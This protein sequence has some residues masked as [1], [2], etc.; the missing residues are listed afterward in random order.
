MSLPIRAL[1]LKNFNLVHLFL[2]DIVVIF[3]FFPVYKFDFLY[4]WDDQWFV[5]NHYTT[6]GF[7]RENCWAIMTEFYRGQYAPLNQFYYTTLYQFLEFEPVVYHLSNVA[8]HMVNIV[9][10]YYLIRRVCRHLGQTADLKISQIAFVTS[11]FFAILPINLEPVVWVAA[12]KVLLYAIFYFSALRCY[13]KYLEENKQKYYY[14]TLLFFCISF[15]AKEQAVS[16]PVC[17]LLIDYLFKRKFN[18]KNLWL[19]KL[20]MLVLSLLFG[21]I[22][23]QS[24]TNAGSNFYEIHQ[25]FALAFYTYVEYFAKSL[26][27]VNLSYLYPF[28]FLVGQPMPWW[29]WIYPIA[30]PVIIYC[31]CLKMNKYIVFGLLFFTVHIILVLNLLSLARFSIIADRYTYVATMGVCFIF[32]K[33]IVDICYASNYKKRT[34]ILTLSYFFILSG[35]S[36]LHSYVWKDV[37]SLKSKISETIR[38]RVD[39]QQWLFKRNLK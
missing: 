8:L 30:V 2:I 22:T 31:F 12:S 19:E 6:D 21:L 33:W 4:G 7:T 24:Q 9:L 23:I 34:V 28:P 27:P 1:Y 17:L 10:V 13:L 14:L 38:K 26:I 11:L 36:H 5:L 20:P 25:R 29:L 16:L 3:V 32:A 39:Y 35:Y 15:G 37:R 18:D